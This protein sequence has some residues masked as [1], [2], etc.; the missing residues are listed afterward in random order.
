M[1]DPLGAYFPTPKNGGNGMGSYFTATPGGQLTGLGRSPDGLGKSLTDISPLFRDL[2][3]LR[4]SRKR[5]RAFSGLGAEGDPAAPIVPSEPSVS[6][7]VI[8][9]GL[10]LGAAVRGACGYAVG[11]AVAPSSDADTQKS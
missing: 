6:P 9:T 4:A 3:R 8:F 7:A 11:K 5:G 10:L 1:S 2:Q